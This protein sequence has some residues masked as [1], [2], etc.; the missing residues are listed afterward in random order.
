MTVVRV[1]EIGGHEGET[2]TLRGWLAARRSSGKIHF[3]QLRDGSGTIQCVMGKNDV[4][5]EVFARAD[6]LAQESTLEVTGTVRA[7]ARAP[8]GYELGVSDLRVLHE[9]SGEYPISPKDHGTAF[10]LEH[11]HLWLRSSRQHAV[12]RIRA[13]VARACR[14]YLDAHGFVGFD[15]P[16]LT[17]AACEGTTTLFPVEYFGDTAYLT[18]SGQLYAE[19]GAL[20]FGKVYV[21]GP[22]FR[23]ERSK[24]R[25]HLTEFWMVEPEM[26]FAG[27]DEDMALAEDFLVHVVERV[28]ERRRAELAV[29]E[30]DV[31]PLERVQ[32]P[33]PRISYTEAVD[34]L[35]GKGVEI[36]WG[37]DLGAEAETTLSQQFDRPVMVYRYP[38]AAKAFYMKADPQD[39]RLALCVDVLAPEGHG[40]I[41]GGGQRED[42][43]ATLESRVAQHGLSRE[44]FDWYLD[45]RRFGSVPH[46]GF[47]MGIERCV[48]WVCGLHH[49]RETIPFP[50][51]LER[52]RP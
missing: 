20:A 38:L 35:R 4:A 21:F 14:E 29:L 22:T 50:R 27:L 36:A 1:D 49:V 46:A 24:T 41:I 51:M 45:L 25:R 7:D 10:L 48:G 33:F 6:H 5:P 12:L 44:A 19:A 26:A 31:A 34:L 8:I 23:A 39:P 32:K 3:L 28:L 15:A 13:E 11:R 9:P 47:G 18:Q 43:L 2:V 40:E 30:R 42:D 16:I 37:D 52:L 17:P